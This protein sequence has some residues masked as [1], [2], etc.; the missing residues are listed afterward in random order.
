L[1]LVT[2][3]IHTYIHIFLQGGVD[4]S[5]E[6]VT[7][8]AVPY[9]FWGTVRRSLQKG[10]NV[11]ARIEGASA[12]LSVLGVE[13]AAS[14]SNTAVLLTGS[15]SQQLEKKAQVTSLQ[16]AQKLS[17]LGGQWTII[18]RFNFPDNQPD[19]T[20]SYGYK[21]TVVTVDGTPQVQKLTVSQLL[22]DRTVL[23]PAFDTTG[24]VELDVRRELSSGAAVTAT[25]KP[26]DYVGLK[27]ED[28]P[29]AAQI[30]APLTDFKF[31]D[32]VRVQVRRTLDNV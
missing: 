9:S 18:P 27:Y 32:G 2:L 26:Q 5:I 29:W 31:Q 3:S 30:Q 11:A 20:V 16:L 19:V 12:D 15:A 23:T 24:R 21:D 4:L 22:G 8:Q 1:L 6:D 17:G 10:W 28:G 14:N 25:V 13:V 7:P